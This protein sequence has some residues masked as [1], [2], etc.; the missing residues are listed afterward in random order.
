MYPDTPNQSVGVWFLL[1][2]LLEVEDK[3]GMTRRLNL[4]MH[5]LTEEPSEAML[6]GFLYDVVLRWK[7]VS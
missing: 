2:R 7:N 5:G 1:Q 6:T 4:G 3:A